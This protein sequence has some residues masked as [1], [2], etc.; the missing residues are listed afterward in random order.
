MSAP[1][2]DPARG[3][4]PSKPKAAPQE[5]TGQMHGK[6]STEGQNFLCRDGREPDAREDARCGRSVLAAGL[7]SSQGHS[8]HRTRPRRPGAG[9]QSRGSP[10]GRKGSEASGCWL[11]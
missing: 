4:V 6:S 8:R 1:A 5:G 2:G 9:A 10:G 7:P 3:R 11:P